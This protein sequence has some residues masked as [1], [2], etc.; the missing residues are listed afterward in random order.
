MDYELAKKLK[1]TG[2]QMDEII[3]PGELKSMASIGSW[4]DTDGREWKI[5][6]LSELIEACTK[7]FQLIVMQNGY[8]TAI[9]LADTG[10]AV[11]GPTPEEAVANLWLV[12]NKK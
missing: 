9:C 12:I 4:M 3:T 11:Q 8:V 7:P 1:E 5:P 10:T 6:T 2:F